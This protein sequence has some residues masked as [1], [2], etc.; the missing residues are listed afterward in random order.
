MAAS[1]VYKRQVYYAKVPGSTP[2]TYTMDH[3]AG[4]FVYDTRNK[5][6]LFTRYGSGAQALAD[7]LKILLSEQKA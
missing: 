5:L 3:T 2:E 6:R 4:S 1:D 7:D